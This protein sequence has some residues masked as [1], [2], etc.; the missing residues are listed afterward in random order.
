M[1]NRQTMSNLIRFFPE[2]PKD[3]TLTAIRK[4]ESFLN[5]DVQVFIL[6]GYAGT[7]KTTMI[8]GLINYLASVKRPYVL[9]AS[10]GRAAKVL[11]DK[12]HEPA[13]TIHS[14]IYKLDE[15]DD[16]EE[17]QKITF[18]LKLNFDDP[19]TIY[20][21]D[22]ASMIPDKPSLSGLLNY[23]DGR[24]LAHIFT[25][26]QGRKIIFVGDPAQLPPVK[27]KFSAA[28][29]EDYIIRQFRIRAIATELTKVW[30][31]Q[32]NSGILYNAAR[33]RYPEIETPA[34]ITIK[35][36]GFNDIIL[37]YQQSELVR[38][39]VELVQNS[40]LDNA[41][42]LTFGNKS[43]LKFNQMVRH[44]LFP[45]S[46]NAVAGDWLMVVYNNY[47]HN[48]ANGQHVRLLDIS[49]ELEKRAN[50]TFRDVTMEVTEHG[51][52][53]LINCKM[54]EDLMLRPE[55]SLDMETENDLMRDFAIRMYKAGIKPKSSEYRDRFL[56]DPY[57][58]AVRVK[59]GY[60]I[61]GHKAQ[62][63]EWDNVMLQLEYSLDYQE[64]EIVYRWIYT[65]ITRAAKKLYLLRN[66]LVI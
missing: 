63:G 30:R 53:Q 4:F 23:G 64:L 56:N 42:I 34:G 41:I 13:T 57:L 3:D 39:Y 45:G 66:K 31:Q 27:N 15:V 16:S 62:G 20:I 6:K 43:V 54:I 40:G 49:P 58:N 35:A 18:S 12:T 7:G 2:R 25:F 22:E 14:K 59:F 26:A 9:M 29:H 46:N 38:R 21:I 51:K 44:Y 55:P 32:E 36:S 60:A 5:S 1:Q 24:L 52:K 33:L 61:T 28:L 8:K 11:S 37:C 10:T 47:K 17:K 48:L 19:E 50:L 65:A